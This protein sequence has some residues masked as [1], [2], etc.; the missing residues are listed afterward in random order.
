MRARPMHALPDQ[1][2]GWI[3]FITDRRG[4]KEEEL[5]AAPEVCL[6]FPRTG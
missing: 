2:A 4:S 6:A 1:N 3:Y 5:R